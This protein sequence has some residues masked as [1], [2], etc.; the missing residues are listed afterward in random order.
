MVQS[1]TQSTQRSGQSPSSTDIEH[2]HSEGRVAL[3]IEKET[4]KLPSDTFLWAAGAAAATSLVFELLGMKDKSRF[5]GQW[6]PSILICGVY[7]KIVKVH[8]S[9]RAHSEEHAQGV[10]ERLRD[11]SGHGSES[12]G[13]GG[14]QRSGRSG[15]GSASYQGSGSSY[16]GSQ[17]T[18]SGGTSGGSGGASGSASRGGSSPSAGSSGGSSGNPSGR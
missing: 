5:I 6:V 7:N 1:Q 16:G 15:G 14:S 2:Q 13:G 18:G 3:A 10:V 11:R 17:S 9:D 4:A 8:G 12:G